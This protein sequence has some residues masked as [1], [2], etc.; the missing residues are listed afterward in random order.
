MN[1]VTITCKNIS[2][3]Q[4]TTLLLELNIIRKQWEKFAKFEMHTPNLKKTIVWGNK[5]GDELTK[6]NERHWR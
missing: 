3:K 4:W 2:S 6:K 5:K 1:K